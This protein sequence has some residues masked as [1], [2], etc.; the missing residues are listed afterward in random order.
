MS[1]EEKKAIDILNNT[2]WNG[3][4]ITIKELFAKQQKEIELKNELIN[5]M[6][7]Y[8]LKTCMMCDFLEWEK[9]KK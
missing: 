2:E 1:E 6:K 7:K 8:L 4:M 5:D 9:S 3:F